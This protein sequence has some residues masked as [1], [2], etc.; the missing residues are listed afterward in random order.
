LTALISAFFF[1]KAGGF[2]WAVGA[3][4]ALAGMIGAAAYIY[5]RC[6]T[7]EDTTPAES[8]RVQI[9]N[10]EN[11]SLVI[12]VLEPR[13][14]S[15]ARYN[16]E[17]WFIDSVIHHSSTVSVGEAFERKFHQAFHQRNLDEV[18]MEHV[19]N[20]LIHA[21]T[22]MYTHEAAE[23]ELIFTKK[24]DENNIIFRVRRPSSARPKNIREE[25]SRQ[26]DTP[27]WVDATSHLAS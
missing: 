14:R 13:K 19:Y 27:V 26:F 1:E 12:P 18:S 11:T 15:L 24:G 2:Q 16:L 22:N 7:S 6:T 5:V 10:S 17:S 4:G 21:V 25:S 9:V 8:S 23:V 20:T 3:V